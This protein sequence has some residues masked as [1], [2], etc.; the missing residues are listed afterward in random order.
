ML[1]TGRSRG[2]WEECD[3]IRRRSDIECSEVLAQ[4]GDVPE[5]GVGTMNG[6]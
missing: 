3:P 2:R 5:P 6:L 4:L 1:S